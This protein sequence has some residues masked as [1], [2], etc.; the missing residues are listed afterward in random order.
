MSDIVHPAPKT[1]FRVR[2]KTSLP[3]LKIT[4]LGGLIW[5]LG[6]SLSAFAALWFHIRLETPHMLKILILFATGGFI[7]FPFSVFFASFLGTG[8]RSDTRFAA[9]FLSLTSCTIAMTAFLFSQQYRL[10]YAQWHDDFGTRLWLNEF[11]FTSAAAV[12][13]FFVSGLRLYLPV[14]LLEL[15][16]ASLWLAKRMR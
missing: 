5:A 16:I 13:Q 15:F 11:V 10:F 4:V 7:S 8:R 6:M 12:Y 2:I 9:S 3:S 1:A 14:G